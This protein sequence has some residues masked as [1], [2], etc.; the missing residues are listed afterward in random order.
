MCLPYG[1]IVAPKGKTMTTSDLPYPLWQM[2]LLQVVMEMK[3]N[4]LIKKIKIAETA[5]AQR[6]RELENKP[7][8]KEERMALHNAVSTLRDL[9]SVLTQSDNL[10][11]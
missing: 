7:C 5:V 10:E 2:P 8:G 1:R 11:G 4:S 6:L 9:K 3:P